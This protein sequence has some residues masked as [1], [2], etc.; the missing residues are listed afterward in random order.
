M[1]EQ[2]DVIVAIVNVKQGVTL[3]LTPSGLITYSGEAKIPSYF[4]KLAAPRVLVEIL[5]G[6]SLSRAEAGSYAV[7]V[8]YQLQGAANLYFNAEPIWLDVE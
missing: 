3:L 7:H 6:F 8:G 2:I 5:D 1:G 4:S